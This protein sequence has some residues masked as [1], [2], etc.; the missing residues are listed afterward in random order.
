[1]TAIAIMAEIGN[2]AGNEPWPSLDWASWIFDRASFVLVISLIFGLAATVAIVWMGIIKE[3]HWDLLREHAG[4][5]IAAVE[6]EAATSNER[7]ATINNETARLSAEAES[8][9]A[10]IAGAN[11]RAA[12]AEERAAEAKLELEKFRAPRS[13]SNAARSQMA[14]TLKKYAGTKF[15]FASGNDPESLSL[16][17]AIEGILTSAGWVVVPSSSPLKNREV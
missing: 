4:A 6:L 7:I 15:E 10:A 8:A 12:K 2:H 11:E 3:H 16:V 5:K 14:D 1:M 17:D 13:I 9:R